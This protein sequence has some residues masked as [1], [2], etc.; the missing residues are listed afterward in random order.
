MNGRGKTDG[1]KKMWPLHLQAVPARASLGTSVRP[2]CTAR[3]GTPKIGDSSDDDDDDD[4]DDDNVWV[5]I[6]QEL[7][8]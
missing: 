6:T 3:H 7:T 8:D 5:H 1:W 2:K 4:D